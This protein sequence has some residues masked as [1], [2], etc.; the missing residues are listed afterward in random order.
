MTGDVAADQLEHLEAIELGHLHVEQH[1]I[2]LRLGHGLHRLEAVGAFGDDLDV[3]M[4]R[5]IFAQH[6]RAPA[7]RRRRSRPETRRSAL[8]DRSAGSSSSARNTRRRRRRRA[9]ASAPNMAIAGGGRSSR[10]TPRAAR[11]WRVG[12]ARILDRDRQAL[13][14]SRDVERN[15]PPSS[16]CAMPCRSAFSASG[17]TISGGNGMASVPAPWRSSSGARR[18]GPARGEELIDQC[19]LL[20]RAG[21]L[22]RATG[23]R[24]AQKIGRAAGTCVAPPADRRRSAR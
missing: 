22:E 3:G 19:Q 23:Q 21:S 20:G 18:S 15:A 9:G 4:T 11:P 1:E 5:Q 8:L 13:L 2:G 17:C 12:I 24:A 7:P 14:A 6:L 10:P 16:G